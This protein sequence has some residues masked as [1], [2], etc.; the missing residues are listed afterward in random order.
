M[1]GHKILVVFTAE[2]NS[3]RVSA[4]AFEL[5]VPIGRYSNPLKIPR[6]GRYNPP[7]LII[8][9][10]SFAEEAELCG[11]LYHLPGGSEK[12]LQNLNR[13]PQGFNHRETGGFSDKRGSSQPCLEDSRTHPVQK[14]IHLLKKTNGFWARGA[15]GGGGERTT[16][17][18]NYRGKRGALE[19][20]AAPI[21]TQKQSPTVKLQC[22]TER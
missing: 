12:P 9:V 14:G 1:I 11:R 5:F 18:G 15:E 8:F 6:I 19:G 21:R 10:T 4:E 16:V 2:Y 17:P 3:T 22:A 13:I 20:P 7:N